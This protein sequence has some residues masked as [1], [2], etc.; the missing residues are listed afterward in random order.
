MAQ[1]LFTINGSTIYKNNDGSLTWTSGAM[2]DDD[3]S[4]PSFGDPD[5][6]NDTSLHHNGNAL[7]ATV[8]RYIVVP[9]QVR[10]CVP[11]KVLGCK[12]VVLNTKN[13]KT[14]DAVVGDIGP[15]NKIGEI[16]MATAAALGINNS[17]TSGGEEE[18]VIVYTIYPGTPAN[19]DGT[20][21]SLQ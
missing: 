8:D 15:K 18:H 21:Y 17:P 10:S 16:S 4:G 13:G 20:V 12:A 19:V 6:Q 14:T 2:I 3:G 5:Y 1:S 11:P 7:N 9:P